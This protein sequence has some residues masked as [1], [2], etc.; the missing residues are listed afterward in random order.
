MYEELIA[1]AKADGVQSE[2]AFSTW[3][4]LKDTIPR[5][6][7]RDALRHTYQGGSPQYF[8]GDFDRRL[9]TA[10]GRWDEPEDHY[11]EDDDDDDDD[12]DEYYN[13]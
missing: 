5:D 6:I 12:Y 8:E 1:E 11:D 10:M 2:I 9:L 3:L 4:K 7:L 13:Y